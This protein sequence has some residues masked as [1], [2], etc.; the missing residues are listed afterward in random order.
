MSIPLYAQEVES[1]KQ[2]ANTIGLPI[3]CDSVGHPSCKS[4]KI[5]DSTYRGIEGWCLV[6][7]L[8]KE[9]AIRIETVNFLHF[10]ERG[11]TEHDSTLFETPTFVEC[12]QKAIRNKLYHGYI[13][14]PDHGEWSKPFTRHLLGVRI[15]IGYN[16]PYF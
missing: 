2:H 5:V 3:I 8:T 7:I 9:D 11:E 12:V 15:E 10:Y 1:S 6:E 4:I 14:Y 13:V 16:T